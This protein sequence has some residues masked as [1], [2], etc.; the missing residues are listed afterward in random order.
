MNS[1]N[2]DDVRT[3]VK[4]NIVNF[5]KARLKSLSEIKLKNIIKKKNPWLYF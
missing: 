5:H 3:F 1:L 2:L 4:K